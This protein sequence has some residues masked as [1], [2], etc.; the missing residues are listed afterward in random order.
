VNQFG[1]STYEVHQEG[2]IH[3]EILSIVVLGL[4]L[5]AN[6]DQA[7]EDKIILNIIKTQR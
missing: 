1:L 4:V 5:S 3:M 7:E 2:A 6:D